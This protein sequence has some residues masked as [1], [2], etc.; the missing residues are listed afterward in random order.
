MLSHIGNKAL[1]KEQKD[2]LNVDRIV[3]R[4]A[5]NS[6]HIEAALTDVLQNR[7][8]KIFFQ[9]SEENTCVGVCLLKRDSN[10]SLFL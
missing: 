3:V 7:C 2:T 4:F 10:A 1:R 6:F 9:L 8:S 5:M